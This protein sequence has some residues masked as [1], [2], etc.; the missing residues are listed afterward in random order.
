M[1]LMVILRLGDNKVV[2]YVTPFLKS[3]H[4][5]RLVLIRHAPVAA[6][7]SPKLVQVTHQRWLAW[8]QAHA[9]RLTGIANTAVCFYRGLRMARAEHPDAITA[10]NLV[11]YG[12][13]AWAIARLTGRKATV[14]LIGTDYNRHVKSRIY[15]APLQAILRNFD[16]VTI[17]GPDEIQELVQRFGLKAERIVFLPNAIETSRFTPGDRPPTTDL[18][19]VGRLIDLKRVDLILRSLALILLERPETTLDIVGDGPSR[20]ALERLTAELGIGAQ[21]RF[22]GWADNPLEALRG[23][24]LF[25]SLSELEGLP[26]TVI[27]AMCVGL[28]PVVTDVGATRVAVRDGANGVVVSPQASAQEIAGRVLDLLNDPA[29]YAALR[30]EALKIGETF[31]YRQATE[32]VDTFLSQLDAASV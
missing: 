32:A 2:D 28:V 30:Q 21:V 3:A 13:I 25:L 19:Y 8:F 9:P 29:R 23:G 27:E 17:Y 11:P 6:F 7:D 31:D 26:A 15:G 14:A 22:V 24:R 16:F 4:V 5:D 18:I 12:L 20:P 10:Y 1:R